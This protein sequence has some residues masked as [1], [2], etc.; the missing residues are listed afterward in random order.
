V[1]PRNAT[2]SVIA[3]YVPC[4][5]TGRKLWTHVSHSHSA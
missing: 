2:E 1:S 4:V 5:G 3:W